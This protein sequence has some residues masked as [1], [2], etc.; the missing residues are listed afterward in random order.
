MLFRRT[1]DVVK[2]GFYDNRDDGP[3]VI[4]HRYVVTG[5]SW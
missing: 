1:Y 5:Y 4:T 2:V 3:N